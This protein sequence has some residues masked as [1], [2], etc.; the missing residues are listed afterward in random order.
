MLLP[1]LVLS[2]TLLLQL[3]LHLLRE[4]ASKALLPISL[5]LATAKCMAVI[6]EQHFEWIRFDKCFL[7]MQWHSH[8]LPQ[9]KVGLPLHQQRM[10]G[11][12]EMEVIEPVLEWQ[13]WLIPPGI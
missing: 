2:K 7:A 13:L 6:A 5:E 3:T 4:I 11:C 12:V 1:H 10:K 9:G 8:V